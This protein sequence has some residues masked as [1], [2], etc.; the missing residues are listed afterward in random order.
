MTLDL[1]CA[2][3]ND[4]NEGKLNFPPEGTKQHPVKVDRANIKDLKGK[5]GPEGKLVLEAGDIGPKE[6]A[7]IKAKRKQESNKAN[8]EMTH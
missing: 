1:N 8:N 3:F 4:K 5:V 7:A 2:N 6:I